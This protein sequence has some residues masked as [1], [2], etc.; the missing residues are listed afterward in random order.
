MSD[1]NGAIRPKP[2]V[3]LILDGWGIGPKNAGNAVELS[4][5][6]NMRRLTLMYPHGTLIASGQAVGLP[7]GEDGNTE[8]GH[9]NIGAGRIVYQDLPRINMSVAEGNFAQN[10]AFFKAL[11]H[12]RQHQSKLHL[13]GLVGSGGVHSSVNHLYALLAA[14][15]QFE[16][17]QPVCVHAFLDGRDSPPTAGV[18]YVHELRHHLRELGLGR[19]VSLMGRYYAMDRDLRWERTQIAYDALTSGLGECAEDLE[20]ALRAAYSGGVTDEFI[21][22]IHYCPDGKQPVV[23]EDNDAVI[24][25]NFR[26]DRPRQ[27]TRAFVLPE[28]E[29]GTASF[30]FDPYAVKYKKSHLNQVQPMHTFERKK[31]LKNLC[32][33]TMTEYEKNLPVEIAFP[34]ISVDYPLGRVLAEAGLKQLRVSET[35]KERFVTYY[36]N[37]QREDPYPGEDRVIIPSKKVATYD[38][39]PQMSAFEITETLLEKFK[40]GQYDVYIVNFANADMVAHTGNLA[41]SIQAC[42]V[43]DTCVGILEEA[44][45]A[46]GGVLCITADH[47]NAEELINNQ[48]GEMDTEH[49]IYPVPFLICGKSLGHGP[50]LLPQ[51]ILADVAPTILQLLNIPQPAEMTGR[52]LLG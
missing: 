13:I 50:Q 34:P 6:V 28:F 45:N 16:L 29:K 24:F 52:Q 12:V 36:F 46:L 32:F 49:S 25:F 7:K 18:E 15:K 38:L 11:S 26:I 8:T 37:G 10:P 41:A 22:P 4:N 42:K 3:L 5:P 23:V 43:V 27:L 14:A 31:V 1:I 9:L 30:G 48:T 35:E 47:G 33:V 2:V 20:A 44:V 21:Q 19:L 17:A 51:G 39:Q 40:H